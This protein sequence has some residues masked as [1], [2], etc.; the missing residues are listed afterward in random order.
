MLARW[1]HPERGFIPPAEFIPVAEEAG[2]IGAITERLVGEA[3]R[4][5]ASWSAPVAIAVNISAMQLRDRSLLRQMRAALAASGLAPERLELQ[6]PESALVGDL[7]LAREVQEE[8]PALGVR[9]ALDEFGTGYSRLRQLKALPISRLKVDASFVRTRQ[10][11]AG[12]FRLVAGVLGLG[13]SL[14][15][16]TIA[17]GVEDAEPADALRAMGCDIGQGWLFGRP[18]PAAAARALVIAQNPGG[19]ASLKPALS[20]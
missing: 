3:C 6:L 19:L 13:Q 10:T 16:L 12:S 2:L 8:L 15:L 18:M 11:D 14:G 4:T 5:A 7:G 9:I 17:E 1:R 20:S